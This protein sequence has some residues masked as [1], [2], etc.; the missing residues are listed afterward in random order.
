VVLI[1]HHIDDVNSGD[2]QVAKSLAT[3]V[4]HGNLTRGSLTE[5]IISSSSCLAVKEPSGNASD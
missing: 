3:H 4:T 1:I 2:T 5:D